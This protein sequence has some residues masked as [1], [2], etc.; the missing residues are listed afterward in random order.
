MSEAS[1]M[2]GKDQLEKAK[3]GRPR[4]VWEDAIKSDPT[5]N[6]AEWLNLAQ[7]RDHWQC[8]IYTVMKCWI[9]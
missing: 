7:D 3:S 4:Y 5:Y 9:S 1:S 6:G 8:L 2:N